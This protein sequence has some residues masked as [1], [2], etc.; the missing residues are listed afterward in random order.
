MT[1][2]EFYVG[3]RLRVHEDVPDFVDFAGRRAWNEIIEA[4]EH[5]HRLCD[6]HAEFLGHT[7][8]LLAAW[9]RGRLDRSYLRV[10]AAFL[11]DFDVPRAA[12][13]RLLIPTTAQRR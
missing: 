9:R 12:R 13:R 11:R 1:E 8:M 2:R 3:S 10:T 6:Y 7:A 4:C 5:P